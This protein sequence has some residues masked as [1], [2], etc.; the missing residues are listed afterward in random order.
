MTT[1]MVVDDERSIRITVC[2]FLKRAGYEVAPA[3]SAREARAILEQTDVDVALIDVVLGQDSGL[4]L[5]ESI[6]R[7]YPR[8]R[9][10]LMTG[11]PFL[12]SAADMQR[13][14]TIGYLTKPLSRREICDAVEAALE[15]GCPVAVPAG[16]D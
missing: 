6:V 7:D 13:L 10:R 14:R 11:N 16:A 4:E 3:A 9:C 2:A 5:L 15:A 8:T 12:D 1:V